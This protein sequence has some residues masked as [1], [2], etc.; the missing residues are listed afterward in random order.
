MDLQ[1][2]GYIAKV[3]CNE[4]Q[5]K[6]HT[7][8]LKAYLDDYANSGM[9]ALKIHQMRNRLFNMNPNK[10]QAM[11]F[12]IREHEARK[13]KIIV[14]SEDTFA[15]KTFADKLYPNPTQDPGKQ[16]YIRGDTKTV[17][18]EKI[19][20][21]FRDDSDFQTIFAS[22]VADNS[23]N[24]PDLCVLIQISSHGGG[25]AARSAEVGQDPSTK[26][27][28]HH[29]GGQR[30]FL[31]DYLGGHQRFGVQQG[32]VKPPTPPLIE[33]IRGSLVGAPLTPSL[34]LQR[35]WRR[36]PTTMSK[37]LPRSTL[38]PSFMLTRAPI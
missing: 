30:L 4:V 24:L 2:E 38:I 34:C 13:D 1:A 27:W 12:L 5:V 22:K 15:L 29:R 36:T 17:E 9:N 3:E 16:C 31:L 26:S 35:R 28:H 14:F 19:L 11:E 7:D 32:P 23:L 20:Q 33:L 21:R 37:E 18:R 6:M 10:F 8:F 25:A